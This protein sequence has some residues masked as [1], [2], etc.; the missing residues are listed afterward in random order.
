MYFCFSD[1]FVDASQ[2]EIWNA[3]VFGIDR[4]DAI[5]FQSRIE[6]FCGVRDLANLHNWPINY[7]FDTFGS[8]LNE[9]NLLCVIL[10]WVWL[11]TN[12]NRYRTHVS[13]KLSLTS[14][15]NGCRIRCRIPAIGCIHRR[16]LFQMSQKPSSFGHLSQQYVMNENN[17]D[18]CLSSLILR[19]C[20]K[21][22]PTQ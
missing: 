12:G 21:Q 15:L 4:N 1:F 17:D 10:L 11:K 14:W 20:V 22:S 19:E 18:G 6:S 13:L 9:W 5:S 3:N 8:C 16:K 2:M 7:S